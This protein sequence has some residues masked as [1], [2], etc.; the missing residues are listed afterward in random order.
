ML[1]RQHYNARF[2]SALSDWPT[3]RAALPE[4]WFQQ[5]ETKQTHQPT[6]RYYDRH[7]HRHRPNP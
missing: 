4:A 5:S 7:R 2:A 3:I 6:S 1:S